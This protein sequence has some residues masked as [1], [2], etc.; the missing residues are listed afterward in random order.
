M[1]GKCFYND[2]NLEFPNHSHSETAVICGANI[3]PYKH[4]EIVKDMI[5][6]KT[7]T[8]WGVFIHFKL[9]NGDQYDGI[10]KLDKTVVSEFND[11]PCIA[12]MK[13]KRKKGQK[14]YV[15]ESAIPTILRAT[16]VNEWVDL[17]GTTI[18]FKPNNG[19]FEYNTG[20][21]ISPEND[22]NDRWFYPDYFEFHAGGVDTDAN[23]AKEHHNKILADRFKSIPINKASKDNILDVDERSDV[24]DALIDN[25]GDVDGDTVELNGR[26]YFIHAQE[27]IITDI[28]NKKCDNVE[29]SPDKKA[30]IDFMEEN[31]YH[32]ILHEDQ[33]QFRKDFTKLYDAAYPKT[34]LNNGRDYGI[35]KMNR[36]LQ[37]QNIRYKINIRHANASGESRRWIVDN[38]GWNNQ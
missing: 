28:T 32:S 36:F 31:L 7:V 19:I 27:G 25:F 35:K 13:K 11:V 29:I 20:F 38:F 24:I 37:L 8:S 16:G 2:T 14:G 22:K 12:K 5:P 26:L 4:K 21:S 3:K 9:T 17:I 18:R 23:D 6:D 33:K 34:D 15:P 30:F 10:W 1:L